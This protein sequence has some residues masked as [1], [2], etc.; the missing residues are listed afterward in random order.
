MLKGSPVILD[1]LTP[2]ASLEEIVGELLVLI[3]GVLVYACSCK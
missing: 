1:P 3:I 2:P